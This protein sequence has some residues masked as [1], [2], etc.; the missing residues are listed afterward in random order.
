ML[1]KILLLP[2]VSPAIN[3]RKMK[4]KLLPANNIGVKT[5]LFLFKT[6]LIK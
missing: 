1:K 5:L 2:N 4:I 3:A 6:K